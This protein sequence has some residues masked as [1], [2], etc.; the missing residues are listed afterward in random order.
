MTDRAKLK[1]IIAMRGIKLYLL[2]EYVGISYGSLRNKI[3]NKTEF[4]ASEIFK[5]SGILGL[6]EKE[7]NDIFF[8]H[9]VDETATS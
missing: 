1:S 9:D 3:D 6:S 7:T 8:A 4:T 2:A 5:M